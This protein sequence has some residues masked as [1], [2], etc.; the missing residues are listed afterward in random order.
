[1]KIKTVYISG[2]I[3]L[4]VFFL[5]SVMSKAQ[6]KTENDNGIV[7]ISAQWQF[8]APIGN[9]YVSGAASGWGANI[10]ANYI[11]DE[12]F[13]GGLF[14]NWHTN[15]KYISRRTYVDGTS[16]TT[17][18]QKRSLFQL[19]FGLTGRY[20]ILTGKFQPYVGL[21]LG[22]NYSREKTRYNIF[23][24][25]DSQWGFYTSPEIGITFFPENTKTIGF[26]LSGYYAYSTN[27]YNGYVKMDGINNI[28]FRV[29]VIIKVD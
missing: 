10:E 22:T 21:K 6:V 14:M 5:F 18:D 20:N 17:M 11:F 27:K 2:L 16:A 8:N 12:R 7:N 25:S 28:G 19:P 23:G 29:G 13:S 24:E 26:N 4:S 3:S 1:M 9:N 15:N